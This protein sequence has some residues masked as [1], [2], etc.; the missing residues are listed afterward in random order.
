MAITFPISLKAVAIGNVV[1]AFIYFYM[2]TFMIG[3]LYNFG[4]IKQLLLC[5]KGILSTFIMAIVLFFLE[6]YINNVILCLIL[7][8]ITGV[9]VY[10]IALLLMREEEVIRVFRIFNHRKNKELI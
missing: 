3:R 10:F 2:N 5:W 8:I 6:H 9:L 4:A 1:T 7:G